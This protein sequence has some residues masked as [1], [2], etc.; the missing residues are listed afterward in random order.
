[1]KSKDDIVELSNFKYSLFEEDYYTL[2]ITYFNDENRT[3]FINLYKELLNSKDGKY[4]YHKSI[5]NKILV[6][7]G[8]SNFIKSL[9]LTEQQEIIDFLKII[10]RS[11][12][13]N[14]VTEEEFLDY[15]KKITN[16]Y[17]LIEN[18]FFRQNLKIDYNLFK[19]LK[20]LLHDYEEI[21]LNNPELLNKIKLY[22]NLKAWK[23]KDYLSKIKFYLY[24]SYINIKNNKILKKSVVK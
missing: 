17:Y 11:N 6:V 18:V 19:L 23:K 4:Y 8:E 13:K 16:E 22:I 1:M 3:K 2:A 14:S 9:S 24:N 21:F 7:F 10:L 20:E 5:I 15:K 12:K